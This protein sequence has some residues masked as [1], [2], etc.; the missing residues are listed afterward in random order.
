M[1]RNRR[2]KALYEVIGK[3]Q[4]KSS[5]DRTLEQLHP[6][7][8]GKEPTAEDSTTQVPE[9][10]TRWPRR[11]KIVQFNAGRIELSMPYQLAIALLLGVVLSVLVVFRLGQNLSAQKAADSA[12]EIPKSAQ[13]V[14]EQA[15]AGITQTVDTTQT[16]GTTQ[17]PRVIREVPRSVKKI[18]PAKSKS[19]NVIVLVEYKARAD[20]VPVQKHFAQYG[21]ET[22]IVMENGRYFLITKDRYENPAK[23]GTDG[24]NAKQRIIEVGAK[25]KGKAP[26][27]YETFAP[28]FFKDAYGKKVK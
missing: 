9:T 14:T 26:K 21:I 17:T 11:P 16:A 28:H 23:P 12:A 1:A 22:E 8:P 15:V 6:A 5:Y 20:L 27:G 10:I 7:E 25:Y 24:Y 4:L 13:K 3:T 18:E 2:K 19:N